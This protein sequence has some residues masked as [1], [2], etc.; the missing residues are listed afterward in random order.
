M[1]RSLSVSFALLFWS[2]CAFGSEAPVPVEPV[3]LAITQGTLEGTANDGVASFKAIPYAAPPTGAMRW[4]PPQAAPGWTGIRNAQAFGPVCPQPEAPFLERLILPS[5]PQDEDCLTLNVFTPLPRPRAALPVMVFIHGG[6]FVS[7]SSAFPLYDGTELAQHGMVVVTL[8]YRLGWLGFFDHPALAAEQPGAPTGNY[9][10]MDQIAALEWVKANIAAFGGDPTN[11]T[12]FGESA[13]AISINDLMVSPKAHGL[14]SKAIAE[15]GLGFDTMASAAAEG[16]IAQAFAKRQTRADGPGDVLEHLRKVS[17]AR[18]LAD[19]KKRDSRS[20]MS[21]MIDGQ[22]LTAPTDALFAAEKMQSIPYLTGSNSNEST[23]MDS[24]GV[25]SDDILG[26][27]GDNVSSVRSLYQPDDGTLSNEALGRAIYND[28]VFAAPAQAFADSVAQS[29]SPAYVY[30]FSYLTDKQ[31]R[32]HLPGVSHGYELPY[33]F[34]LRGLLKDPV[35]SRYVQAATPADRAVVSAVQSFWTN[36]ARTGNPNASALPA[37][38]PTSASA[39]R[40]L[41]IGNDGIRS[42]GNFRGPELTFAYGE[43][44]R[45]TGLQPPRW[46]AQSSAKTSALR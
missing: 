23:L 44:A 17:V 42:V 7:G 32:S 1:L 2:T 27:L 14:F 43:W 15:S 37:W 39:A 34:G 16:A 25:T 45:R 31:R 38:T 6:A 41:V 29:G 22:V 4:R 12:V 28:A 40:T 35:Y 21:P 13:G 5:Q 46:A 18:I 19:Q 26:P 36:F 24:F 8:N 3:R 9:G 30:F 33:V 11:V 20:V 10:L